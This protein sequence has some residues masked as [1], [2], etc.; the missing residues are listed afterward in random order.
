M[1]TLFIPG[2]F[3]LFAGDDGPNNSKHV[4]ISSVSL[5]KLMEKTAEHHA[6]GAIGAI[7]IGGLG[8]GALEIGFELAGADPQTMAMFGVGSRATQPYTAYCEI[9]DKNGNKPLEVKA[10]AWGR[11]V[12]L[13]N[14]ELKRGELASQTHV[15][16]EL[17][18]YGLWWDKKEIY[19][20]DFFASIWRVNGVDQSAET[21][22][23]LRIS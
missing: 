21:N 4:S 8:L 9:R 16:K 12:E 10:T 11:M 22:S 2:A 20:Y 6:G 3:N 14:S 13:T 1:S 18:R 19:Y 15:I 23:I 7:E 5:P 17:T